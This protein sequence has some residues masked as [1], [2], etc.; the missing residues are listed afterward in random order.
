MIAKLL[1]KKKMSI[2]KRKIKLVHRDG[3]ECLAF[4]SSP[5]NS[6]IDDVGQ[7]MSFFYRI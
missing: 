4:M 2:V 1:A 3:E 5:E 7:K 6:I